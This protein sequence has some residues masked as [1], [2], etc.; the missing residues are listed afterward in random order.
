MMPLTGEQMGFLEC[1][2]RSGSVGEVGRVLSAEY[3][4]REFVDE[5][6]IYDHEIFTNIPSGGC[7]C[8]IDPWEVRGVVRGG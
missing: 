5:L 3:F 1:L 6:Y 8:N 7:P 2:W 4:F